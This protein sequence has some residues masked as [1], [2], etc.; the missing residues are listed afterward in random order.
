MKQLIEIQSEK[1]HSVH[2]AHCDG[3]S[4]E[5]TTFYKEFTAGKENLSMQSYLSCCI[6]KVGEVVD[7]YSW[8]DYNTIVGHYY[9]QGFRVNKIKGYVKK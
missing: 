7:W 6:H 4:Q 3:A 5:V 1:P 9:F 8:E 2:C